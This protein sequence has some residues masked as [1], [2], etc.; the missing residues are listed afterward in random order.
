MALARASVTKVDHSIPFVPEQNLLR[1]LTDWFASADAVTATQLPGPLIDQMVASGIKRE[2]PGRGGRRVLAKP[3]SGRTR[4]GAPTPRTEMPAMRRVA[5]E[6]PQMRA[7]Y[8]LAA[9]K[10]LTAAQDDPQAALRREHRY[11]DQHVAAGRNRRA[12]A[13]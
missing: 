13:K 11:L 10:R 9:S 5:S 8:V 2:G 12:A 6:E 3:M 7:M 4:H 1:N